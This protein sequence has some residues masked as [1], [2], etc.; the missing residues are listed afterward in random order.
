VAIGTCCACDVTSHHTDS[1]QHSQS[2]NTPYN[3]VYV[4]CKANV[5]MNKNCTSAV[6][7]N[8]F[9]QFNS[10]AN[11]AEHSRTAHYL[12]DNAWNILEC[13]I[14]SR[15]RF[16]AMATTS[17]VL[18]FTSLIFQNK[19]TFLKER[20]M[21]LMRGRLKKG[22][23]TMQAKRLVTFTVMLNYTGENK[24]TYSEFRE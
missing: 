11:K 17:K 3:N 14:S 18:M 15:F 9:Q 7:Y 22:Y 2:A 12:S 20:D 6:L 23:N 5:Y 19:W 1:A 16:R 13:F 10:N 4:A 8:K 21:K 24:K